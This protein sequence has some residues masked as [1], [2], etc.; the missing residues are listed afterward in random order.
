MKKLLILIIASLVISCDK[1]PTE[2]T[3]DTKI[4]SILVKDNNRE[5]YFYI[6]GKDSTI[7]CE[8]IQVDSIK[9]FNQDGTNYT[10]QVVKKNVGSSV[11][12]YE[13]DLIKVW[14]R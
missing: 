6:N 5:I 3:T 7:N 8:N 2:P 1:I 12:G 9:N 4:N 14:R 11:G 13:C 10:F